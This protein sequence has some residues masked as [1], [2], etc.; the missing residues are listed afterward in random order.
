MAASAPTVGSIIAALDRRRFANGV[1]QLAELAEANGDLVRAALARAKRSDRVD[2]PILVETVKKEV[3]A[4]AEAHRRRNPPAPWRYWFA[5][6]ASP[7]Q[8]ERFRREV[9]RGVEPNAAMHA[10]SRWSSARS[11]D[12]EL[13]DEDAPRRRRRVHRSEFTASSPQ[14]DEQPRPRRLPEFLAGEDAAPTERPRRGV[15]RRP[16]MRLDDA[17]HVENEVSTPEPPRTASSRRYRGSSRVLGPRAFFDDG[18]AVGVDASVEPFDR[19]PWLLP[20]DE[21]ADAAA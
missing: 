19:P 15:P 17:H 2:V 21:D 10:C 7:A 16:S 18:E 12:I 8:R 9:E 5:A 20:P 4:R 14:G 6:V 11:D 13:P 1:A 3:A